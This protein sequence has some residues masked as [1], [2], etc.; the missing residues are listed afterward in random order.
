[1]KVKPENTWMIGD[2]ALADIQ[3]A[4][5]LD[6]ITIQKIHSGVKRSEMLPDFEFKDYF[7]LRKLF[8]SCS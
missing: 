3:G 2:C 8:R 7:D 1:M 4:K 5:K 6:M